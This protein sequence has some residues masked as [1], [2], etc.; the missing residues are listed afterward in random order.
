MC[1]GRRLRL[2]PAGCEAHLVV[3][4]LNSRRVDPTGREAHLVVPGLDR[5]RVD[6]AGREA[7]LVVRDGNRRRVNPAGREA[8]LVVHRSRAGD[9]GRGS[10]LTVAG[11]D[12]RDRR[13]DSGSLGEPALGGRRGDRRR[14]GG[15]RDGQQDGLAEPVSFEVRVLQRPVKL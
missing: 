9:Q 4:G 14:R 5:R 6:P 3:R 2:D 15:G 11:R 12:G 7:H 1:N 8:R 13:A 10:G